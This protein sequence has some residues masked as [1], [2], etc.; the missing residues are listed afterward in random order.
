[1]PTFS[2]RDVA[3]HSGRSEGERKSKTMNNS[4]RTLL[5]DSANGLLPAIRRACARNLELA[6]TRLAAPGIF[7]AATLALWQH[8]DEL[9]MPKRRQHAGSN[10]TGQVRSNWRK[11]EQMCALT[12][13]ELGSKFDCTE[14]PAPQ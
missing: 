7:V 10:S 4:R 11:R 1:V 5:S 8:R 2:P 6:Q 14:P 3:T 13:L 9:R 12:L